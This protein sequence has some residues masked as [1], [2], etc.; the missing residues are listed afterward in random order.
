MT[1]FFI[2]NVCGN[3][4][5]LVKD[6]GDPLMCCNTPMTFLEPNTVE[7]STEKHI[8]FVTKTDKGIKIQVGSVMHPQEEAHY[9]DFIYVKTAKGGTRIDLPIGVAPEAEYCFGNGEALE[10]YAYCNL[11]G[12]WKV[13]I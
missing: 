9:I 3:I 7:A 4:I 13:T 11:H 12:L 8:P 2:C 5:E 10:V 6:K 1:K